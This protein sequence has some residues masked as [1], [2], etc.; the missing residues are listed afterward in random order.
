MTIFTLGYASVPLPPVDVRYRP[1]S[2]NPQW[3]QAYL[4]RTLG[5]LYRHVPEFGNI[6]YKSGGAIRLADEARGIEI[7]SA[8]LES[9]PVVLTCVCNDHIRCHRSV[10]AK[11]LSDITG[12][13]IVHLS[14]SDLAMT[15]QLGLL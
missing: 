4:R 2:R 3:R 6:L 7:V 13:E 1:L 15:R 8:L 14:P 5:S 10:V 11:A 12:R 9:Q